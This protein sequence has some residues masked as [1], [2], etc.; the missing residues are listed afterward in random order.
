V[1][2]L[3]ENRASVYAYRREHNGE[4]AFP[5]G[6][7]RGKASFRKK[8][9]NYFFLFIADLL[10]PGSF[11]TITA[12]FFLGRAVLLGELYPFGVAFAA[13]VYWSLRAKGIFAVMG[14]LGGILTVVP[15][16]LLVAEMGCV[17]LAAV[18][19]NFISSQ[20]RRPWLIVPGL[21]LTVVIV[22]RGSF[23]AFADA[24]PYDYISVSFEGVFAAIF[25]LLAINA[26][27]SL[28]VINSPETLKSEEIF[29]IMALAGGVV[30]GTGEIAWGLFSLKSILSYFLI[31]L[32]ALV[33]GTGV[34]AAAG[35]VMGIIPGLAYTEM[36]LVVGTYA[37]SGLLAGLFRSFFKP[38]VVVGF[39]LGNII[40]S[41]YMANYGE[42]TAVVAQVA[43]AAIMILCI[44]GKWINGLTVSLVPAAGTNN[45]DNSPE[46]RARKLVAEKM[47]NWSGIFKE[48]A[49]SF[50]QTA[51]AGY[52]AGEEQNLQALLD[53]VRN[54]VCKGC[55]HYSICWERE[56]Y[57]TYQNL[58]AFFAVA[59]NY[60]RVTVDDLDEETQAKCSRVKELAITVTCLHEMFKLNRYWSRRLT[61][62]NGLV[63]EQLKGIGEVIENLSSEL[64]NRKFRRQEAKVMKQKL[65]RMGF[66]VAS[67][68]INLVS[69]DK[70]EVH[71]TMPSCGGRMICRYEVVP[72]LSKEMD[73]PM[74]VATVSC[75][76]AGEREFC[77]FRAYPCPRY[78]LSLG[79]AGIAKD[80]STV[81]GDSF[82]FLSLPG[83]KFAAL[84][85]D[86]MGSG[87]RAAMES[88]STLGLIAKLMDSGF[89]RDL[90]IKT[91]NS[92]LLLRSPEE[93]FAT[94]DMTV[95]DIYTAQAEF[96]KIGASPGFV[97]RGQ[98]V[99]TV[100]ANSLPVGIVDDVE[101]FSVS[102]QLNHGDM[103][104]MV[105][106]GVLD[107]GESSGD[108]GDWL[109]EVLREISGLRPQEV[110]E[111]IINLAKSGMHKDDMTVVVVKVEKVKS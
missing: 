27:P 78:Q 88:R 95:V 64:K 11:L 105:T 99:G 49:K 107:T 56:F 53:E 83:G 14:V 70:P 36:P 66:K 3:E 80:G 4:S 93:S 18:G 106:D 46:D 55:S 92:I 31:L 24:I 84:L 111:L 72:F 67:L 68:E 44:P 21:V 5:H 28:A 32:A 101:V 6:E 15:A 22:V 79:A 61:E 1:C 48:I 74:S 87:E 8:I 103:V 73:C 30:A 39:L 69:E 96:A 82:M 100:R 37:F 42:L 91:V 75:T 7:R 77:S 104:V 85:S 59:D 12:G 63:S 35:A 13:A 108:K 17:I 20:S 60:G 19:S 45:D 9:A 40:L 102:K 2:R 43:V 94:V 58:L 97:V 23:L 65:K 81:S 109:I 110:A 71:V 54:K 50:E 51:A 33:G 26:L 47:N 25:T 38:G 98:Q 76:N 52:P 89:G 34:G 62:G 41:M 29:C 90:T 57:K 86:G 10:D 16:H